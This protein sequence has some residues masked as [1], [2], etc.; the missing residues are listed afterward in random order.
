MWYDIAYAPCDAFPCATLSLHSLGF[1]LP[2]ARLVAMERSNALQ[3][4]LP[5][6]SADES[7]LGAAMANLSVQKV[8]ERVVLGLDAVKD[9]MGINLIT[10]LVIGWLAVRL[11]APDALHL[12]WDSG[13]IEIVFGVIFPLT[14]VRTARS[15][16]VWDS[17]GALTSRSSASRAWTRVEAP[18][19]GTTVDRALS[20]LS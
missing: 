14:C 19:F 6:E 15:K 13:T 20:V 3:L 16:P 8:K 12:T 10:S 18:V 11:C 5:G 1:A 9:F 17:A 7:R 4:E 2:G